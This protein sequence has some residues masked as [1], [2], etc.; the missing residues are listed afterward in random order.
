MT[1]SESI[2]RPLGN[3][4]IRLLE[5]VPALPDEQIECVLTTVYDI[6]DAPS[7]EALSYV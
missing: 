4:S 1:N 7:F 6:E 2:Y 3:K 5:I